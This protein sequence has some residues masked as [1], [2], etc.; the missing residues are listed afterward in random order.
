MYKPFYKDLKTNK[1]NRA[2]FTSFI[3]FYYSS[4]ICIEVFHFISTGKGQ[5]ESWC[6]C[7]EPIVSKTKVREW[8][9]QFSCFSCKIKFVK[10]FDYT[11]CKN[12]SK[13]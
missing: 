1:N 4:S 8:N 5:N 6:I 3:S 12:D 9:I 11:F 7:D 2:I 13:I 10:F